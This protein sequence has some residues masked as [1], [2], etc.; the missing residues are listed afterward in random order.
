M[1]V[2]S[3]GGPGLRL[4]A[5]PS[6]SACLA[7]ML[8]QLQKC[9]KRLDVMS[10]PLCPL[11]DEVGSSIAAG[12]AAEYAGVSSHRKLCGTATR[13]AAIHFVPFLYSL[14][15]RSVRASIA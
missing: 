3:L 13:I 12:I 11:S 2:E 5:S 14:S 10:S 1:P 15:A 6:I 9:A 7:A 8:N 4:D